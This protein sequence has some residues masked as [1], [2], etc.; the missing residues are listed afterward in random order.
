MKFS[1][2]R[3]LFQLRHN[4]RRRRTSVLPQTATTEFL[5]SRLLLASQIVAA[6]PASQTVMFGQELD[7]QLTYSVSDV[8]VTALSFGLQLHYDSEK[9]E[10]VSVSNVLQDGGP[11]VEDGP[12]VYISDGDANTCLLYTSPSP[13]DRQ[14]SRM[15]SSA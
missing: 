10:F 9:L 12:A 15:P 3:S 2:L 4:S 8:S 5:E 13:R 7:I 11:T 6:T 14:K 1:F